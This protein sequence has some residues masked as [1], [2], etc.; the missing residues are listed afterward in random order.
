[1]AVNWTEEQ[2]E[3]IDA[4]GCNLLV[5]AAAGSG[6]TAVLAQRILSLITDPIHPIDV[7]RILVMTFTNAAAGEMRE[8]IRR[9][10]ENRLEEDVHNEHLQ[11][12]GALLSHASIM[13]IHSFALEVVRSH[14]HEIGLDPAFRIADE[15]ECRLIKS[16]VLFGLL[17]DEYAAKSSA[18]R[19]FS[20]SMAPSR[21]D[22]ALEELIL[23]FYEYS[24][25]Y[26]WPEQ[27]RE[28]AAG[29]RR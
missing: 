18:F 3:V 26:P 23:D 25:A 1:M 28:A 8:R 12:Q 19:H 7:D 10:I 16:D 11:K 15:G 9:A 17:E 22:G 29:R 4:R 14:F 5:S 27:W 20:E 13:T 2:K 21:M 6:K 24:M